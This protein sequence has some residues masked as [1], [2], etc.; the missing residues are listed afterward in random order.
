MVYEL[1][2]VL[3]L[4]VVVA[5]YVAGAT[6]ARYRGPLIAMGVVLTIPVVLVAAGF[7]FLLIAFSNG[8]PLG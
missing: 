8:A 5:C 6:S 1:L 2:A 7:V 3:Y 4:F